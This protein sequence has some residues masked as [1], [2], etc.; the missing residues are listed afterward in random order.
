MTQD[1]RNLSHSGSQALEA[2]LLERGNLQAILDS[3][4]D[5]IL[6]VDEDLCISHFNRAAETIT[7][8][9]AR[10]AVGQPC[11]EIFHQLLAG[12]ASKICA[13]WQENEFPR[14]AERVLIRKDGTQRAVKWRKLKRYGIDPRTNKGR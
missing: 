6:T 9:P 13:S 7:G 12:D 4:A 5:G 1:D 8:F 2:C 11:P 14:E 3:V 10:E